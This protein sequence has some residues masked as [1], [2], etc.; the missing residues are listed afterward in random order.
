MAGR[1]NNGRWDERFRNRISCVLLNLEWSRLWSSS[2]RR[3]A[4]GTLPG[5]G[6]SRNASELARHDC[7]WRHSQRHSQRTAVG[8]PLV[9]RPN[10]C[11]P[12][13]RFLGLVSDRCAALHRRSYIRLTD[14]TGSQ[15]LRY[16]NSE[17][18]SSGD[19]DAQM[20]AKRFGRHGV[21]AW[22]T[23]KEECP[24]M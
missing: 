24:M 6:I 18:N 3:K 16:K 5:G 14:R 23:P 8:T 12:L 11:L 21:G 10:E 13:F 19:S 2:T 15:H 7:S 9:G 17:D 4:R 1:K 22:F 20:Y